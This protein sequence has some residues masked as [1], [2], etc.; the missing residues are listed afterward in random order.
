MQ[1]QGGRGLQGQQ[2]PGQ[3]Q[4]GQQQGQPGQQGQQG[5]GQ[6]GQGQQGQGQQGQGQQG[7]GGQ[8]A[9]NGQRGQSAQGGQPNGQRNGGGGGP[10]GGPYGA[11]DGSAYNGEPIDPRVFENTYRDTL[12]QLTQL[13]PQVRD[14]ANVSRDLQSLIRDMQRLDPSVYSNDPLLAARIH[15]AVIGGIEQVEMELRRKVDQTAGNGS[16]RSQGGETVPQ[17]YAEAVA[18]YFRKLSK[19][20]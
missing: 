3:G 9:G 17:G 20:K 15:A 2:R 19:S 11:W 5:R 8:Q 14:D 12:R 18:E 10:N 1:S 16:V 13:Q 7:Q 4:Q 6:Q